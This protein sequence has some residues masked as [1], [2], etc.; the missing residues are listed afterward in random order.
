MLANQ[1]A[2]VP[3]LRQTLDQNINALATLVSRPPESV[4]VTGGSL[5]QIAIPRVTPGLPSE[6]LTQRPTSGVRKRS[7]PPPPPMS[8]APARSSFRAFS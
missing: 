8:A 7:W 1:R 3:P 4:R 2:L 5:N 6:L